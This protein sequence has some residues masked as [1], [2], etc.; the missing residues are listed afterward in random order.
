MGEDLTDFASFCASRKQQPPKAAPTLTASQALAT[1]K[2]PNEYGGIYDLPKSPTAP[3]APSRLNKDNFWNLMFALGMSVGSATMGL[4]LTVL[5]VPLIVKYFSKV[6]FNDGKFLNSQGKELSIQKDV[7][8]GATVIISTILCTMV[9]RSSLA[10]Y[11]ENTSDIYTVAFC[12]CLFFIPILFFITNNCPISIMFN[13]AFWQQINSQA[14]A[15]PHIRR[16]SLAP[17]RSASDYVTNPVY[18]NL[19]FNLF[20]K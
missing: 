4:F 19:P 20:H 18:K 9:V 1:P 7:P 16:K 10:P 3:L 12:F 2:V 5:I 8:K 15:R 6:T 11:L 13:S 14:A 17:E